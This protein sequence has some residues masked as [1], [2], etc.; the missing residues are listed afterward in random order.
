MKNSIV[1]LFK[2]ICLI[3]VVLLAGKLRFYKYDSVPLPGQ[4]LDEYSNSWVGMSLIK[5]GL[6]VGISGISGYQFNDMRY[7]NVDRVFQST[8]YGNPVSINYPWFDHP[9]L[10][11]LVTGGWAYLKGA[12]VFEEA[13]SFIIRKPVVILGV[14][15]VGLLFIYGWL[16]YS[17]SVGLISSLIYA[18]V[19]LMVVS[20]RMIQAENGLIPLFLLSLILYKL[21][22]KNN[23][24]VYLFLCGIVSGLAILFKLSGIVVFLTIIF[25]MYFEKSKIK[26][27]IIENIIFYGVI[28]FSIGIIFVIYGATYDLKQFM[29]IFLS[30]SNRFY[31]IGPAAV[32]DLFLQSRLTHNKFITEAWPLVGWLSVLISLFRKEK[33]K[34]KMWFA[35]PIITY[36]MIYLFFG[37]QPF[38]WYAY[39]FF[40]FLMLSIGWLIV[41]SDTIEKQIGA[42]ICLLLPF[43]YGITRIVSINDFQKYASLWR[44]GLVSIIILFLILLKYKNKKFRKITKL[45]IYLILMLTIYLNIRYVLMLDVD[46][47]Y[48]VS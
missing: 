13:N 38:G 39:P 16:C 40:P 26:K 48:K 45:L 46:F 43:G 15:S 47:W 20:S 2:I 24:L 8:A 17:F 5:I 14:I 11:G 34:N 19:P 6:P 25:L 23:S 44:W 41:N 28:V 21:F 4:S 9:P 42:L 18:T 37:S 3:I 12:R 10:M 32:F 27:E 35:L 7:I 22:T 36:L 1:F 31:G 30:N 33:F 29:A